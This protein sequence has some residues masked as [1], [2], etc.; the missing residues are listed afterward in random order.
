[1][2]NNVVNSK[3]AT[4]T[5]KVGSG[6]AT[7]IGGIT[8]FS[9][10]GSGSAAV[11]D[12]TDLDSGSKEKMIGVMDEGQFKLSYNV[13][14]GD[15]GQAALD[16]ARASGAVVELKVTT[17]ATIYT[18]SAFVLTNEKGGAVD[19]QITGSAGFEITGSVVQAPVTA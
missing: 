6:A 14:K 2:A 19:K 7:K 8:D 13:I 9:G 3:G 18:F 15:A 5:I 11:I 1:M 10:I 12:I 4:V 17:S 16:T